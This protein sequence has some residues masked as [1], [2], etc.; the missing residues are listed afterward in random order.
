MILHAIGHSIGFGHTDQSEVDFVEIKGAQ[1]GYSIS[2]MTRET[3]P[4]SW[5]G[6]SYGDVDAFKIKYSIS[7]P[8]LDYKDSQMDWEYDSGFAIS[9]TKTLFDEG[10]INFSNVVQRTGSK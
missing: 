8:E 6:I 5:S 10:A 2:I 4:L 7:V 9:L 1:T 3:Y